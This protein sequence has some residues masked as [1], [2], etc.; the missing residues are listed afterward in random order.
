M[1]GGCVQNVDE[2]EADVAERKEA[3]RL[4]SI[5]VPAERA[6][7]RLYRIELLR[8]NRVDDLVLPQDSSFVRSNARKHAE[9]AATKGVSQYLVGRPFRIAIDGDQS[10]TQMKVIA[11]PAPLHHRYRFGERP[12]SLDSCDCSSRERSREMKANWSDGVADL[13]EEMLP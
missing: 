9:R 7:R 8:L 6:K 4:R 12:V 2:A 10:M 5:R 1:I 3:E 11:V 13:T